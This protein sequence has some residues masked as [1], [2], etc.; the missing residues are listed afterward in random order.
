MS[1][2]FGR[3][4]RVSADAIFLRLIDPQRLANLDSDDQQT[5]EYF[6]DVAHMAWNGAFA[7]LT[8]GE[9]F[10]VAHSAQ[11]QERFHEELETLDPSLPI[12]ELYRQVWTQSRAKEAATKAT[13]ECPS[14][15][16]KRKLDALKIE[17]GGTFDLDKIRE[18]TSILI[19]SFQD[20]QKTL[21]TKDAPPGEQVA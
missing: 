20:L 8:A 10:A 9:Q 7:L 21:P 1:R 11:L 5:R 18:A 4:F 13:C 14:C 15:V 17:D 12:E 6:L 16:I 19:E 2:E 3:N